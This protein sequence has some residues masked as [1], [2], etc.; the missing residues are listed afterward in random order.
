MNWVL[1][2]LKLTLFLICRRSYHVIMLSCYHVI[3]LSYYHVNISVNGFSESVWK[4]NWKIDLAY[5]H[6]GIFW[7]LQPFLTPPPKNPLQFTVQAMLHLVR[8]IS[9]ILLVFKWAA[10]TFIVYLGQN[11]SD[12]WTNSCYTDILFGGLGVYC[13]MQYLFVHYTFLCQYRLHQC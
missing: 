1:K 10:K 11:Y 2:Y 3:M 9:V 8:Y 13:L 5:W 7:D 12:Q 4:I 6:M